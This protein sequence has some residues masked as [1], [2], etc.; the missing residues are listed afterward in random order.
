MNFLINN[1]VRIQYEYYSKEQN[2]TK[3]T[4]V[5]IHGMG[6]NMKTWDYFIP[7]LNSKY[8]VLCFNIRGHGKSDI[9]QDSFDWNVLCEDLYKLLNE[10][11]IEDCHIAGHGLGGTYA[12]CFTNRYPE[13]VKR[14]IL[15]STLAFYP[16]EIVEESK[17]YRMKL[18][19]PGNVHALAEHLINLI[20]IKPIDSPEGMTLLNAYEETTFETYFAMV[21]LFL[22]STPAEDL[23]KLAVPTLV[24]AGELDILFPHYLSSITSSYIPKSTF[25]IVPDASNMTFID[26]PEHTAKVMDHFMS[27]TKDSSTIRPIH[28][29]DPVVNGMRSKVMD[30]IFEGKA[31]AS[32]RKSLQV[33]L[34]NGFKVYVNGTEVLQ[35]WNQRLAKRLLVYLIFHP[36]CIR[37]SLYNEFWPD[38]SS[39]QSSNYLSVCLN[40]LKQLLKTEDQASLLAAD[41]EHIY[42]HGMLECDLVSLNHEINDFFSETDTMRKKRLAEEVIH[43]LPES[44]NLD[45]Y[46]DWFLEKLDAIKEKL[47]KVVVWLILTYEQQEEEDKI[48][49]CI[50]KVLPLQPDYLEYY[51][52]VITIYERRGIRALVSKWMKKREQVLADFY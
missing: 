50:E 36:A 12:V 18:F 31:K 37:E 42:L 5:L 52:H 43:S 32:P 34:M 28:T 26:Q 19:Q 41:K 51:D 15:I 46:D 44:L 20:T 3:E 29:D 21:D 30:L 23:K 24:L 6:L 14:L 4:I 1:N 25:H 10:L 33:Q 16:A 39:K 35:G 47:R 9:D 38:S 49:S 40:H 11:G 27:N 45:I 17:Q 2:H 22:R 48:I 8:N 7:H 13:Y